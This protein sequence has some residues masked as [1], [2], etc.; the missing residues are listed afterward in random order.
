[1]SARGSQT[2]QDNSR[3]GEGVHCVQVTAGSVIQDAPQHHSERKTVFLVAGQSASANLRGLYAGHRER[4]MV[5]GPPKVEFQSSQGA[6]S[7]LGSLAGC[8]C[9]HHGN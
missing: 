9:R 6:A 1:M 5:E 2:L 3:S 4:L 8:A 7:S